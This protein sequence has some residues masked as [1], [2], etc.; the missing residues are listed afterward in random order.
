MVYFLFNRLKIFT[1]MLQI[2]ANLLFNSERY[3]SQIWN[4]DST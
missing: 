2:G 3:E 4:Y 1:D